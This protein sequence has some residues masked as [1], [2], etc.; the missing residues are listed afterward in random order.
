MHFWTFSQ[1]R[2]WD[3]FKY[4]FFKTGTALTNASILFNLLRSNERDL[5]VA[6]HNRLISIGKQIST[7]HANSKANYR[8]NQ[9]RRLSNF[10]VESSE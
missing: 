7:N 6:V 10:S 2:K 4:Q 3:T 5:F 8:I 1:K 9:K